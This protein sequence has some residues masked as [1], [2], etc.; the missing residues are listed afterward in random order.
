MR[1]KRPMAVSPRSAPHGHVLLATIDAREIPD[2]LM[3]L[4]ALAV[5]RRAVARVTRSLPARSPE[6]ARASSPS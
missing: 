4:S 1:S 5:R 3:A 2:W 6:A